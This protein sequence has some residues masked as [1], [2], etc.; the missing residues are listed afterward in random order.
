ML[1]AGRGKA[2][3]PKMISVNIKII[4]PEMAPSLRTKRHNLLADE[5]S[6]ITFK[7]SEDPAWPIDRAAFLAAAVRQCPL[8]AAANV[9]ADQLMDFTSNGNIHLAGN[10]MKS[11][12]NTTVFA[13]GALMDASSQPRSLTY[14]NEALAVAGK[15]PL[16]VAESVE[17][18]EAAP[19]AFV[20]LYG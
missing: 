6:C 2:K 10:L 19:A 15:P 11:G 3:A 4:D 20:R 8:F 9:A 18:S 5:Q 14:I 13:V 1:G 7:Q 12:G 17:S 16:Q